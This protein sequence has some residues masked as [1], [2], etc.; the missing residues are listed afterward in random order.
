MGILRASDPELIHEEIG[1]FLFD[2]RVLHESEVI[3][4]GHRALVTFFEDGL[5]SVTG[6]EVAD[7]LGDMLLGFKGVVGVLDVNDGL[8]G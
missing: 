3:V 8:E 2:L 1:N 4:G 6:H 5:Y 7:E